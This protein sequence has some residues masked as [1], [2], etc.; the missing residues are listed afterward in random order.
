M[1]NGK[2]FNTWREKHEVFARIED[3]FVII[4]KHILG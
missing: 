3:K 1:N 2:N 4:D